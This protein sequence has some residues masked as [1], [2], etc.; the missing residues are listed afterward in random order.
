MKKI[1]GIVFGLL[2]LVGLC[3]EFAAPVMAIKCPDKTIRHGQTVN[4]LA[5]CN[6]EKQG[7]GGAEGFVS[8]YGGRAINILLLIVGIA[9]VVVIIIAGVIMM[10]S[11]GDAGKLKTAKSAITFAIIGLLISLLAFAVVNFVL[12]N[13]FK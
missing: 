3:A 11:Q 10:T 9:S 4:S 13:V 5:E 6:I 1:L 7:S 2:M 8:K 12:D